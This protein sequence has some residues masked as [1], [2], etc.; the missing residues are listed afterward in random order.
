MDMSAN[1]STRL[2]TK[3]ANDRRCEDFLSRNDAMMATDGGFIMPKIKTRRSAA[4]R[5]KSTKSGEIKR[6]LAGGRHLLTHKPAK[7][8]RR[9]RTA[10]MLDPSDMR[11]VKQM[12]PYG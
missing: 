5:F 6:H 11:R 7:R 1:D 9:L 3:T 8:R 10:T 4:K 12:L 2:Y